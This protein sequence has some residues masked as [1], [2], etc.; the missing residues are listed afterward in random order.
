[1]RMSKRTASCFALA[2]LLL[3]LLVVHGEAARA[4]EAADGVS[5][6][7]LAKLTRGIG[8]SDWFA[9]PPDNDPE[10]HLDPNNM[11]K[12][13]ALIKAMGFRHVRLPFGEGTIA[14]G[15]LP[16]AL[17][18]EK[19]KRFDAAVDMLLAGGLGVIAD[20]S[21]GDQYKKAIEKDDVAMEKFAALWRVLAKHLSSRDPES[22]FLELLNE[23]VMTDGAR[24][25]VIQKKVLAAMRESAPRHTLLATSSEWSEMYR[26]PLVEVVADRNVIY[27][28]HYYDP[29]RFTHQGAPWVGDWVK[30]LKNAPYPS[31]PEAVAKVLDD[32][33]DD[34][35]RKLM[36]N[37]GKE[38]WRYE[39]IEKIISEGAAWAK[40]HG[41]SLTCNEFGVYREA[42]AA[43]RNRCIEDTRKALEKYNIGWCMW[44]YATCFGV[45]TGK[46]GHRVPDVDTLKALGLT[47]S[48]AE[49]QG[50]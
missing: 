49:P 7:R 48:S 12:D 17:N 3:L 26:L 23:P 22:L 13:V 41:V 33:P 40:K 15:N 29:V 32:L 24:W 1:M 36:I 34:T 35:A 39:K 44:D 28:V 38:R 4:A 37:Y 42:P 6:A 18:P 2:A 43:D 16:T 11:A 5:P 19:M 25:N 27:N 14:D 30:G 45:V 20:F 47:A 31:S 8:L 9:Q 10:G 50:K 46:P 21:A